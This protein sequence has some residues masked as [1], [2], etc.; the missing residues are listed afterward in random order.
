MNWESNFE[1]RIFINGIGEIVT[2]S[3]MEQEILRIIGERP[4][5]KYVLSVG[6]DSQVKPKAN[7]TKFVS[8]VH[9]HRVGQG[10]WGWRYVQVEKRRYSEL[11]EKIMTECQLTQMLSYKFFESNIAEKVLEITIDYVYKDA[12]FL[13][14]PHVDIGHNGKTK[15][16]IEEVYRM[17]NAMGC[18]VKIKPDSYAASGYADKYSKW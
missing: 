9:L 1:G 18:D 14:V 6:T 15:K 5:A 13:L 10:A 16:F 2:F 7:A 12:S 3:E 17:F 11:K 4:D 8:V